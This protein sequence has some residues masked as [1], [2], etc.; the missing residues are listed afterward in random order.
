M[1]VPRETQASFTPFSQPS[2]HPGSIPQYAVPIADRSRFLLG[3][4]RARDLGRRSSAIRPPPLE[5]LAGCRLPPSRSPARPRPPRPRHPPAPRRRRTGAAI[6]RRAGLSRSAPDRGA[7]GAVVLGVIAVV[8]G[9]LIGERRSP[10]SRPRTPPSP[11]S[12]ARRSRSAGRRRRPSRRC[13]PISPRPASRPPPPPRPSSPRSTPRSRRCGRT[14]PPPATRAARVENLAKDDRSRRPALSPIVVATDRK[15]GFDDATSLWAKMD[16][17][18]GRRDARHQ[19]R[20]GW[21]VRGG[22][23]QA[24]RR[25][26]QM[27]LARAQ[28]RDQPQ[29]PRRRQFRGGGEPAHPQ[30]RARPDG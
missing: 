18:S 14:R 8:G 29:R 26:R 20:A 28:F 30:C 25:A 2:V 4:A 3:Q 12:P 7:L 23:H 21:S 11:P 16:D 22:R 5:R 10:A 19:E 24:R 13:A 27:D 9:Y 1:C 6:A 17:Q 15:L